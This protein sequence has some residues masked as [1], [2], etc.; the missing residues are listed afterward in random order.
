MRLD[1][2]MVADGLA[3]TRSRAR[4]LVVRGFVRVDGAICQKP[5]QMCAEQAAIDVVDGAPAYVSRGAEKLAAALTHFGVSPEGCIAVDVG[6]STGGFTEVLLAH[7]AARVYAVDVGHGQLHARIN[8]DPRV[9]MLE[10]TDARTLDATRIAEP[11]TFI[12]A[13]VS[14]I[15]LSKALPAV[16]ALAAP[17]CVLIALVKPQ[18]EVGP[19]DVSK[20][21][22]VR[23]E[24]ARLRARQ[25]FVDWLGAQPGWRSIGDMVS[26]IAGGDGNVEYLV[27]AVRYE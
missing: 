27:A 6:A 8:A 21:G 26:P 16:L 24:A 14:F 15:A 12:S 17:G 20:G 13:D 22:I 5:A 23:D 10:G 3:P 18:F 2:R 11:V 19:G 7:G 4:D 25:G 1:S 9:V